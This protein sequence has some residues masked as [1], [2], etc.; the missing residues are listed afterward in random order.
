MVLRLELGQLDQSCL[1]QLV[2][3]S[4]GEVAV[5]V[6]LEP[7]AL[8][9]GVP[10][11]VPVPVP[12]TVGVAVDRVSVGVPVPVPVPVAVC[13]RVGVAVD[14]AFDFGEFGTGFNEDELRDRLIS[15]MGATES[16]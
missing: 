6:A 8:P 7:V 14:G 4:L 2:D 10:V 11:P 5:G 9:V 15:L 16:T 13:V 1:D 3:R 12:V